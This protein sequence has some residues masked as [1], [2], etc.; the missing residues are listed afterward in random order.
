MSRQAGGALRAARRFPLHPLLVAAY[1]VLFLFAHNIDEQV[2]LQPL[3]MPLAT[4]VGG[5]VLVLAGLVLL[6]RDWVRAGLLTSLAAA[7]FFGYGHAW[8]GLA[9]WLSAEWQLLLAWGVIGAIGVVMVIR[10]R[11]PGLVRASGL[12]TIVAVVSVAINA[13]TIG[14]HA[15]TSG[16][17][18]DG[19][20]SAAEPGLGLDPTHR[21]DVY[22]LIFDRYAGLAALADEY[23]FDNRPF[24]EQL[25]ARGFYVATESHANYIKTP[26]SLVSSLSMDYLDA[27]E[28]R[29]EAASGSD[30]QPI[31]ARLRGQLPVPHA[32]RELG[33]GY[34]HVANWWEP[35]ATNEEADRVYRY[36]GQTEFSIALRQTTLLRTLAEPDAPPTDPWDWEVLRQHSLYSLA[37]LDE[38]PELE[39]PKYVFAH[40]LLPHD[41]YVFDID[42]SFTGREAVQSRGQTESYLRQLQYLNRRIIDLVDRILAASDEAPIIILQADEGPFPDR[43]RTD[44]W[45][46]DWRDATD[47]ELEEKF[48]IL[49]AVYL[50]GGDPAEAGFYSTITPV[51]TF[52]VVFNSAFGADLP[53]LPDRIYAHVGL[54]DFYE[55]F[56]VTD[57]LR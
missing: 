29:A 1:P 34:V 11:R 25:E 12:L 35:T 9:E 26:L 37:R 42:G 51:N 47:A 39:G 10:A 41:P 27:D 22:Y 40:L 38:I 7:L 50:A 31:H 14:A 46:F 8:N 56:E 57:R 36:A 6:L 15:A 23:G 19:S 45:A 18:A 28:L 48:G 54:N 3:W 4:A 55:E 20:A 30:R 13:W 2:T 17:I 16:R 52:R 24:Y 53:L 33:Y 21:P 32:L 49:H 43:Y 44:E 5:T